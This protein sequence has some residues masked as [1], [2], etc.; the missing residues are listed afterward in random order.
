MNL[1]F[2]P[3]RNQLPWLRPILSCPLGSI[4][5]QPLTST[6]SIKSIEKNIVKFSDV[7]FATYLNWP[8]GSN[9]HIIHPLLYVTMALGIG[10]QS[11]LQTLKQSYIEHFSKLWDV[12]MDQ[13]SSS[14]GSI[15]QTKPET[16]M[17]VLH[18]GVLPF[19]TS[20]IELSV[21]D[22]HIQQTRGSALKAKRP[23]SF[24]VNDKGRELRPLTWWIACSGSAWSSTTEGRTSV[25]PVASVPSSVSPSAHTP[26]H[27]L[28]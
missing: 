14:E 15:H 3:Q 27:Q 19:Y 22:K 9:I 2:T 13:C 26:S 25:E 16:R 11:C 4:S 23:S 24:P 21:Q 12:K 8:K 7:A 17:F 10:V 28:W 6:R 1:C 20:K 18:S 5:V